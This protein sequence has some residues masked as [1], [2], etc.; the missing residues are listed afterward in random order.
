MFGMDGYNVSELQ[1]YADSLNSQA[2]IHLL[3]DFNTDSDDK[4]IMDPYFDNRQEDFEKC[5]QQ[6]SQSC[7]KLLIYLKEK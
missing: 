3:G 1:R 6:I 2:K 7:E 5:F 4:I